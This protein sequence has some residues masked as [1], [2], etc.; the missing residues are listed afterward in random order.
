M[1]INAVSSV[2]VVSSGDKVTIILNGRFEQATSRSFR[3]TL[4]KA[5]KEPPT[6]VC[7]HLG[8]IDYIDSSALGLLLMAREMAEKSGKTV[9]LSGATGM[10]RKALEFAKLNTLFKML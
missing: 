3:E 8:A 6:E 7:I 4:L 2:N 9:T 5:L 1:S 10:V